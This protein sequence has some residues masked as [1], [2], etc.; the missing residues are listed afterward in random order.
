M[1]FNNSILSTDVIGQWE[2]NDERRTVNNSR[3]NIQDTRIPRISYSQ[4]WFAYGVESLFPCCFT[5][6]LQ[7]MEIKWIPINFLFS[8]SLFISF[9]VLT[10]VC[11]LIVALDHTQWHTHTHT[12]NVDR[13]SLD[14]G[15][16]RS[17]NLYLSTHNTQNRH[18]C[19]QRDSNPQSQQAS[20]L[21][22]MP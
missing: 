11:L 20:G 6:P 14:E 15:S 22:P 5:T 8:L 4:E 10:S 19:P 17:I 16:A 1:I 12:Q 2:G 21:R 9:L 13:A 3:E 18:P 7:V